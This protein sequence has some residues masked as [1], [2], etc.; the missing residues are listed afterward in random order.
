MKKAEIHNTKKS[1]QIF[2]TLLLFIFI[3]LAGLDTMFFQNTGIKNI[4]KKFE[5][6]KPTPKPTLS[7]QKE[8]KSEKEKGYQWAEDNDITDAKKCEGHTKAFITGCQ[9]Y[10]RDNVSDTE[11]DQDT[12]DQ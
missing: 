7:P 10:V 1:L 8:A 5:M 11:Q 4:K 3:L 2:I 9:S 6:S 12:Q